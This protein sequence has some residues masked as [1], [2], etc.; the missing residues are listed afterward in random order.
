MASEMARHQ[1]S[2]PQE[3]DLTTWFLRAKRSLS[4]VALCTQAH[5][6]VEGARTALHEASVISSRC[7]FL[8][9]SLADQLA[10]ASQIHKM[11][12]STQEAARVEFEV[13]LPALLPGAGVSPP[14]SP[15]LRT[16]PPH[17]LLVGLVGPLGW[18]A[19]R[20]ASGGGGALTAQ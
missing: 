18:L 16:C 17:R 13:C 14:V 2:S 19:G 3:A 4:S 8:R 1:S 12:H 15:R 20:L 11:M 6:L 10:V 9:A 5:D 7:V